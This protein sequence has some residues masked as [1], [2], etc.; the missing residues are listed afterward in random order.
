METTTDTKS[1]ITVFGR[2]HSQLLVFKVVTAVSYAFSPVTNKNLHGMLIKI[3]TRGG[4]PLSPLLKCTTHQRWI[5]QRS[6]STDGCQCVPFFSH[7]WIQWHTFASY[8]LLHQILCL[9]AAIC[10]TATN[11]N[12]ILEGTLN[13]YTAIPPPCTYDMVGQHNKIRGVT[14]R[15]SFINSY[16]YPR[17]LSTVN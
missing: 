16:I 6:A 1:T 4:D 9:T 13:F 2:A 15:A 12:G 14:C 7:R 5:H 11:F 8:T 17:Y 10:C 3:C